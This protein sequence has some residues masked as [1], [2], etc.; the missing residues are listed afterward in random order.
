MKR[1]LLIAVI[2]ACKSR[3]PEPTGVGNYIFGHTTRSQVHDGNCAPDNDVGGGRAGIWCTLLP[4]IKVGT[5]AANIDA[6]FLGSG[7]DA[8]LI[9]L[10]LKVR[11]CVEDEADRWMRERFGPPFL[12]KSTREYWKNSFLWASAELPS[13]PALCTIRFLPIGETAEIERLQNK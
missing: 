8:P 4:P 10:E 13:E 7:N 5:K 2:A 11:G 1:V 12:T 6:Y 9:E 3:A